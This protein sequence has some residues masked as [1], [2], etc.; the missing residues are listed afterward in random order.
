MSIFREGKRNEPFLLPHSIDDFVPDD[1]LA[2]MIDEVVERL[3]VRKI[4][5]NFSPIGRRAYA[6]KMLLKVLIYGFA[7]RE[8]SSR[9]LAHRCETDLAYM[10][11][12]GMETPDFRTISDFRKKYLEEIKKY[13][14]DITLLCLGMGLG[15]GKVV[16]IDG[17]KIHAN[18]SAKKSKKKEKLDQ[19]IRELDQAIAGALR[20]A[21]EADA[22]EDAQYG[23]SRGDELPP[24]LRKSS[25]RRRRLEETKRRLEAEGWKKIN[26]TDPDAR[27]MQERH[28]VIRPAYNCQAAVTG[29]GLIVA[30][31]CVMDA[32]DKGQLKPMVEAARELLPE[33]TQVVA[34]AGYGTYEAL[35]YLKEQELD[36]YVRDFSGD[37]RRFLKGDPEKLRYH[38]LNFTYDAGRD[39][40]I[41]PEGKELTLYGQR[42]FRGW[43]HVTYKGTACAQCG[44]RGKCTKRKER[45]LAL[46][47]RWPLILEMLEKFKSKEGW[48]LYKKRMGTVE[49]PF[50]N[51]KQNLGFTQ[52]LLRGLK[53]V[54]G[55]YSLMCIGHN[56][57]KLFG[58][59]R[60]QA[61]RT[62]KGFRE[63]LGEAVERMNGNLGEAGGFGRVFVIQAA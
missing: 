26:L 20:E 7:T 34:D 19:I 49:P 22:A 57:G 2:R 6:P 42:R 12:C 29:D 10:F 50:G 24:G 43:E 37:I 53:K 28:G 61:E 60:S 45:K 39:C 48:E 9:K 54:G 31:D 62:G 30:Q 32:V 47:L 1:H 58:A 35:G 8:R 14:R 41:C 18:A 21:E 40:F 36:G 44:V 51:L 46:D 59:L 17:T 38:W 23:D 56:L 33:L 4:E 16:F 27:L 25:E 13:F 11:L 63:L 5:R 3:D 52:F 55:E 15:R